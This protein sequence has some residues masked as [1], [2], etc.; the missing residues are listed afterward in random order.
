M[1]AKGGVARRASNVLC[2]ALLLHEPGGLLYIHM[3]FEGKK[4]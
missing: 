4:E 3:L 2:A 1:Q